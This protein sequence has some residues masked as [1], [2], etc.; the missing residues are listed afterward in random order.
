MN[1]RT[2]HTFLLVTS[3]FILFFQQTIKVHAQIS[4][5][6]TPPSFRYETTLR[7]SQATT[8]IPVTF[9]VEDLKRVDEWQLA[10]GLTPPRIATS[11]DVA[12]NVSN[13]GHWSTLP[14]GETIWQLNLRAQGAIAIIL[15]YADF[16]IPEGGKL[17]IYNAEKTQILGAYTYRTHSSGG[18]FVTELI[19][20]DE[21]TLEYVAGSDGEMPRID[22]ESIG[23]AYNNIVIKNGGVSLRAAATCEVNVNCEEGDA[24]Q[25]QKRGVC[26]MTQRIGSSTYLCTGSLVN[27]TANDLKP[28]IISATHCAWDN[29]RESTAR[30]MLQWTFSFHKEYAGC[31]K[32]SGLV[33]PK[34]MTGCKKIVATETNGESDGLLVLL[35]D[36]IPEN[37]SVYYNG[38]DRRDTPAQSGVSIHHPQGDQKKISTFTEP[39]THTTFK[40]NG[41]ISGDYNAHWN[42]TFA[43]TANG[44][45]ITENGSSGAPLFNESKLIVGT[46][47]GGSSSCSL[48][49]GLNLYG[50]MG[51]HWNKYT[52]A[53]ST[54]M[55]VWLDP[56]SSGAERLEGRYH[57]LTGMNPPLDLTA[58][59]QEDKTVRLEWK[60]PVSGDPV[61]YNIYNNNIKIG[62][63]TDLFYLDKSPQVGTQTYGV[64]CVYASG[65][66]SNFVNVTV[67]VE[68]FKAP[69]N[70]AANYTMQQ[71]VALTWDLP[72]Y[73]Q[74]IYWGDNAGVYQVVVGENERFYFGQKWN[75]NEIQYF[76]ENKIKS[77][78]FMPIK[79]NTYEV[80]I[81]QGDRTYTQKVTKPTYLKT[82]TIEL[83]TPFV[84][85][86]TKDLIV[87]IYVSVLSQTG[88]ENEYPAVCDGGPAVQGKGNIYSYDAIE[89]KTLYNGN[90]DS[91][92][93]NVNFF[94]A[95]IV[96]SEHGEI[97]VSNRSVVQRSITHSSSDKSSL[98]IATA[99]ISTEPIGLYSLRPAAFPVV[100]G[101]TVYRD[102][103]KVA[104]I[105]STPRRYLDDK[106]THTTSYQVGA[107]Y[108][109]SYEGELSESVSI[110]PM[111]NE[112]ING[113]EPSIYPAVF[114]N[115]V[116]I[117]GLYGVKRIDIYDAK[118]KLYLRINEPDNI[119]DTQSLPSGVYFFRLSTEN[120]KD[121][122]LRG[123][124]S[125]H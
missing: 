43:A 57:D 91:D 7:S 60:K 93:F 66:E 13:A 73:E 45:G 65:S 125:K 82:N 22:I 124:K 26:Y 94:I 84:I 74:T 23:Y 86:G 69:I 14:S 11:I 15:Y 78:K 113:E 21:I 68:E 28:Y 33:T 44:H 110:D 120:G 71:K 36:Y 50:K 111:S 100:T 48:P 53:D 114:S 24:W 56:I 2:H 5:G 54:R 37:Y 102:G 99:S 52:Q 104:S 123:I 29:T 89:W 88:K 107:I 103:S 112:L 87:A 49:E 95:A 51:Y 35:N 83:A 106:P 70:V 80:Y 96:S 4:E 42:V 67:T 108:E 6:G 3:I 17:F 117:K 31:D 62:E 64:S 39:A 101:Y 90:S 47:T 75:A 59:Y 63:T 105:A 1:N 76:N 85:D 41:G 116:E 16:Y 12:L 25:S 98:R 121:Y 109:D 10:E 18:P 20:G 115:Q 38:W 30:E 122:V 8:E 40:E 97:P 58:V 77:V 9:Y 19:A 72:V 46:L 81:A 61:S 27:N 118:G 55:D 79:N 34:T 119:V 32:S 92:D